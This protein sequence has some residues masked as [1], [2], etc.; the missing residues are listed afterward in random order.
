MPRR[1]ELDLPGQLE[2]EL[3]GYPVAPNSPYLRRGLLPSWARPTL[4]VREQKI[5]SPAEAHPVRQGDYVY[6][7]APPERAQALDRFFVD[8]PPPAAPDPRL[9]GD[10]FVS[11][12]VTLGAL[13]DIYGLSIAP[14]DAEISLARYFADESKRRPKQGDIVQLG[15]IALVAHRV[16]D[17]RVSSVGLRLAEDDTPPA[18]VSARLKKL[19]R[20]LWRRFG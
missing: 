10:F 1:V 17:G 14:E 4:V 11:G 9:L 15:P 20:D 2:Q 13:A 8:M 7:L 5:L 18:T 12:D 6:L 3:V 19:A 16:A